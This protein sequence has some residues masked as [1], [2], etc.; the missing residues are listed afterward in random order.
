MPTA[1]EVREVLRD[2][3]ETLRGHPPAFEYPYA[4]S[5]DEAGRG[6]DFHGR[7]EEAEDSSRLTVEQFDEFLRT[8]PRP[9]DA[10]ESMPTQSDRIETFRNMYS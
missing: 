7:P 10:N 3:M 5:F 9:G 1:R 4:A 8:L 2:A 6:V